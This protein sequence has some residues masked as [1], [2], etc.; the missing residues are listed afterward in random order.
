MW[1][2]GTAAAIP[3]IIAGARGVDQVGDRGGGVPT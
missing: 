1:L 2:P 3:A